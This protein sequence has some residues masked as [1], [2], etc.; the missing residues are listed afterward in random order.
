LDVH[1]YC[2]LLLPLQ[3]RD[4]LLGDDLIQLDARIH[5]WREY[6]DLL[7]TLQHVKVA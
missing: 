4:V 2:E 7:Q 6:R 3:L 1:R 5:E